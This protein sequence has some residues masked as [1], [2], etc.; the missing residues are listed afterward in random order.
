VIDTYPTS[1]KPATRPGK[2][3]R[4]LLADDHTLVRAGIRTLLEKISGVTVAGEASDGRELLELIKTERPDLV[5]LDISMP[6]LN[7]LELQSPDRTNS[8]AR[9]PEACSDAPQRYVWQA[10]NSDARVICSSAAE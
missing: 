9:S 3:I 10:L 8:T 5:L 2:T 4:V 7:G 6:G 1:Q